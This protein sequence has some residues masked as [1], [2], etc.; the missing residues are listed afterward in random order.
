[1]KKLLIHHN[2]TSLNREPFFSASEEF[3][4]DV[5]FDKDVDHYIDEKLQDSTLT[6]QIKKAEIIFIKIAL[7]Q[8]YLEYLGLRV[9]G[10]IRLTQALGEKSKTPI[11]LVGEEKYQ[12][13]GITAKE[14]NLLS[15]KGI[16]LVK[17]SK[18]GYEKALKWYSDGSLKPS[19]DISELIKKIEIRPPANHR[20]HHSITNEWSILRWAKTLKITDNQ[21]FNLLEKETERLLY[22]K[23]LKLKY[24]IKETVDSADFQISEK[25]KVLLIDDEWKKGWGIIFLELFKTSDINLVIMEDD[26]KDKLQSEIITI[27]EQKISL[28]N[29]DL[30][31]LDLR[32]SE[33][34]FDVSA[35]IPL[36]GHMILK[37]IK[38]INPGIQVIL[39]TASNKI[40]NITKVENGNA[41]GF[42]LKESPELSADSNYSKRAVEDLA[43]LIDKC[44]KKSFLKQVFL[45]S[46]KIRLLTDIPNQSF[47]VEF[48]ERLKNNLDIAFK[49]LEETAVSLKYFNYAYLQL[50]QI[51]EDFIGQSNVFSGEDTCCVHVKSHEVIVRKNSSANTETALAFRHGKYK[52]EKTR[53]RLNNHR[54][55]VNFKVSAILIFRYGN[56]NSS[57][58]GWTNIYTTRNTKAAHFNEADLIEPKDILMILDFILYFIDGVNQTEI[59]INAG[60]PVTPLPEML[61]QLKNKFKN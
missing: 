54:P 21:Q 25:G 61:E 35:T 50:F 28:V 1:M 47:S 22:Y 45:I 14:S 51:I 49:L 4:F 43:Q 57:V 23:F 10:H 6:E 48:I 27:C 58:K 34:D 60:L 38:N 30:V 41:D 40:W 44:L 55:D 46:K 5:D 3:V 59:N 39:L 13:L 42:I 31:I 56:A 37:A 9:A 32:L 52:I 26:F 24:P 33:D 12:F 7:S 18:L 17:D 29:P 8:N 11:V 16:Y 15:T 19:D 36:T 53:D 20:S 2:N